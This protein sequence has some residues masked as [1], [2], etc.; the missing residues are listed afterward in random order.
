M[1]QPRGTA[2][3]EAKQAGAST[4][5]AKQGPNA[6]LAISWPIRVDS[7]RSGGPRHQTECEECDTQADGC[8]SSLTASLPAEKDV[9]HKAEF[10]L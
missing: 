6:A 4:S 3:G 2:S 8:F 9:Q 10:K 5:S 7:K 1:G